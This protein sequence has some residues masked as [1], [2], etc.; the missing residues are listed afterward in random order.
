MKER[1]NGKWEVEHQEEGAKKV[2]TTRLGCHLAQT[3]G[4]KLVW[5]CDKEWEGRGG[6]WRTQQAGPHIERREKKEALPG[7]TEKKG[8]RRKEGSVSESGNEKKGPP[9]RKHVERDAV[10][11][12]TL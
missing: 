9:G 7:A 1:K 10:S 12:R 8:N 2:G 5:L 4:A 11:F 3:P 6:G